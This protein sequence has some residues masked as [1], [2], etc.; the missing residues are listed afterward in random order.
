MTLLPY[1][2]T[3]K[4]PVLIHRNHGGGDVRLESKRGFLIKI[5]TDNTISFGDVSPLPYLN[6]ESYKDV[7]SD[8]KNI[9]TTQI[10][11]DIE[12]YL[13]RNHLL[14]SQEKFLDFDFSKYT[15]FPSLKFALSCVFSDFYRKKH[16]LKILGKT[17]FQPLLQNDSDLRDFV[18]MGTRILKVKTL[19]DPKKTNEYLK[20]LF[21]HT[22]SISFRIDAN[23]KYSLEDYKTLLKGLDISRIDYIEDPT[24][25]S[26]DLRKFYSEFHIPFALDEDLSLFDRED[27]DGL[28]ALVIKPTKIGDYYSIKR[29]YDKCISKRV[30]LVLSS[31][32]ESHVGIYQLAQMAQSLAP[33]ETHGLGTYDCY[34]ESLVDFEIDRNAIVLEDPFIVKGP[35]YV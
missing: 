22:H 24:K 32:Y 8:C 34:L 23:K 14:F 11:D 4:D 13:K 28:K 10:F 19:S 29:I 33:Q 26:T 7:Y 6:T 5:E 9:N 31:S 18:K 30:S 3:F 12:V 17:L 16:G 20:D 27:L 25:T 35:I 2:L 15:T 1:E 21:S